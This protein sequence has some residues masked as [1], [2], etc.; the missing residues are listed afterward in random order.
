MKIWNSNQSLKLT[1]LRYIGNFSLL[2]GYYIV[3]WGDE[4]VGLLIRIIGGFLLIP[5]FF[6]LKMWDV[7][8]LCGFY[9]L[10]EISRLIHLVK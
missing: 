6:R 7:L 4:K 2:F 10:I 3:L 5:S 1:I 9:S 8:I